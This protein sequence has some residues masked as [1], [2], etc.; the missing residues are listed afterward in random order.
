MLTEINQEC[1]NS[2]RIFKKLMISQISFLELGDMDTMART[3][4][5]H[6][7]AIYFLIKYFLSKILFVP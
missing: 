7:R 3:N 4:M 5:A 2:A 1:R 6:K